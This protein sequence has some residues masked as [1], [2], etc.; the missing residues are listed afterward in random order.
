M[1]TY[2]SSPSPLV[3]PLL[4]NFKWLICKLSKQSVIFE[5]KDIVSLEL[6]NKTIKICRWGQIKDL[7]IWLTF[8][9]VRK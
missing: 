4:I 3:K 9:K 2:V 8:N 6:D 1:Q 7:N 5:Q